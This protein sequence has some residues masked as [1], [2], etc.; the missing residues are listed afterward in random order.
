MKDEKVLDETIVNSPVKDLFSKDS[1]CHKIVKSAMQEQA[2][3]FAEWVESE[4]SYAGS[5]FYI[6]VPTLKQYKLTELYKTYNNG[7]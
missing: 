7:E 1:N 3:G 6:H 5:G 4:C 2:I